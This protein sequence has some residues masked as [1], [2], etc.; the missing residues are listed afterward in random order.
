MAEGVD[1]GTLSGRV[2]FEDHATKTLDLI[3]ARIDQLEGKFTELDHGMAHTAEGVFTGE[4]AFEAL[5][6]A[7]ELTVETLKDMTI[8]GAK[9]ADI[10]ENFEH[11]TEGAGRLS[12]TLL[13]SLKE[14]T[15]HTVDD[16]ELIKIANKDLTVGMKLTDDQFKLLAEGA[17]GLAK[18]TGVDAKEALATMNDAM[19]T[20]RT[21]AIALMTGKIDLT[22]SEMD[23][24]KSLGTTADRLSDEGKLQAARNAILASV[25]AA[26]ERLGTQTDGLNEKAEQAEASWQNFYD[27]LAMGI[28]KSPAVSGAFDAIRDSVVNAFGG[29][30]EA[31]IHNITHAVG[32]FADGVAK[33][34]PPIIGW[35]SDLAHWTAKIAE[36][37]GFGKWIDTMQDSVSGLSLMMQG[38]SASQATAM[39]AT[40]RAAEAAAGQAKESKEAASAIDEHKLAVNALAASQKAGTDA[41]DKN[42]F[43]I[44]ETTDELKKRAEAMKEIQSATGS[45]HEILKAMDQ[46][47][48]TEIKH[49]LEAGVASDK[50]ATAYGLTAVQVGAVVKS[51]KESTEAHKLETKEIIDS[52]ARW[53][54]YNAVRISMSGTATDQLIA[55]IEHWRA[56]QIKSHRDAKTDTIDFYNW[57]DASTKQAYQK[58]DQQRLEADDHSK[59]H[60]D[61]L[62]ADAEDAYNFASEHADQFS[63]EY[64]EDLRQT[65]VAAEQTAIDWRHS[66]G[67]ALDDFLEKA[68]KL[69]ESMSFSFEITSKNFK[70]AL[71]EN[72]RDWIGSTGL[73]GIGKFSTSGG[74]E[75]ARKGYSFQ[76]II[77]ILTNHIQNPGTPKGP[78]IP[79]F[80]DGGVGDFGEGTLAMLHGHE[81]VVPLDRMGSMGAVYNTF[82]VNGTARD[83]AR[84]IG[85]ILIDQLKARRYLPT[86]G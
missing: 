44:K 36:G 57:L 6:G 85:S 68:H 84:E 35:I 59:A 14:G 31:I 15:H 11:L 61:R 50:L 73:R 40:Q 20:G 65:K 72:S 51:L 49:Y 34:G 38:Y 46:T 56:E 9:M 32:S 33:Y 19:L 2:E 66:L 21:R 5:K 54:D 27:E 41:E 60:F 25:G 28:A 47:M 55:D 78:R 83:T 70:Q 63:A 80:R 7:I 37:T 23:F 22:K 1:I 79:G 74:E 43:I 69:A 26:T 48:V 53:A 4:A 10:T 3:L 64:I 39:I 45:W 17:H 75:L 76:E 30:K 67:G 29:D 58:S 82:H 8:E 18:A 42:K 62:K 52:A 24:A 16:L 12:S 81:A 86:A 77:D 71:E 13:G